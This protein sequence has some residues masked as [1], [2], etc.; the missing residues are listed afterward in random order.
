MADGA[1]APVSSHK[2][3]GLNGVNVTGNAGNITLSGTMYDLWVGSQNSSGTAA[4]INPWLNFFQ[5]GSAKQSYRMIGD[6]SITVKSDT[7]GNI[8]ITNFDRG[9]LIDCSDALANSSWYVNANGS[10]SIINVNQMN[11]FVRCSCDRATNYVDFS[12]RMTVGRGSPGTF[13]ARGDMDPYTG[14][15]YTV[16]CQPT[17]Q[18][19]THPNRPYNG[20]KLADNLPFYPVATKGDESDLQPAEIICDIEATGLEKGSFG[21]FMVDPDNPYNPKDVQWMDCNDIERIRN[22]QT[23]QDRCQTISGGVAI[24]GNTRADSIDIH[25]GDELWAFP[26]ESTFWLKCSGR[27]NNCC[28]PEMGESCK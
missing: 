16:G 20:C 27:V 10:G 1:S 5:N 28:N 24:W 14:A 9:S 12:V 25:F 18:L 7:S 21:Y 8:T 3:S 11:Q 19:D 22:D 23:M 17:N 15:P 4:L 26:G 6:G 2:I 13:I